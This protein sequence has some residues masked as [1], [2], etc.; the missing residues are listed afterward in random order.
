[1]SAHRSVPRLREKWQYPSIVRAHDL[2]RRYS[3]GALAPRQCVVVW[4][5]KVMATLRRRFRAKALPGARALYSLPSRTRSVGL[6]SPGGIGAPGTIT[7]CE[8]L[9]ASG[10]RDL[11]G[12]GFAGALSPDLRPGDVVVCDGAVRDEGTSH[13]Y[14]PPEL[15]AVPSASLSRWLR[16]ALRGADVACRVGPSWTTDAPYRETAAELRHYRRRGVLTVDMEAS[17]LFIF[18]RVRRCRTAAVFVVSDV[19]SE[20]GWEPRFRD[21]RPRLEAVATAVL[22]ALTTNP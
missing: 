11:I 2:V 16:V 8:E 10:T 20:D 1:M 4:N 7:Q 19:L 21:V 22:R 3:A 14:A 9:V 18:G 17:A 5:P 15:R 6:V 12:V 13:H